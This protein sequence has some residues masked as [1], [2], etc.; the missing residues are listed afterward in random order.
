MA[1]GHLGIGTTI[2]NLDTEQS[3]EARSCRTFYETVLKSTFRAYEWPFALKLESLG[4]IEAN[5]T[6][7]WD[8]SYAYPSGCLDLIRIL[9]GTRNDTLQSRIRYKIATIDEAKVVLTD[10]PEAVAEF[11]Y[12]NETVEQWP[13]DFVLAISFLLAHYIAP[14]ITAGDPFKRGA[15][16]HQQYMWMINSAKAS[17]MNE[18]QRDET[19]DSEFITTRE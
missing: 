2:S 15:Q 9:S 7:E 16:A 19:P 8:Y 11:I 10:E 3:Q 17:A 1:L 18:E 6:D 12:Y 4:L 14:A 13:E 5:P